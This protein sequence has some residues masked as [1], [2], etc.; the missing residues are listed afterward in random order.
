MS[1]QATVALRASRFSVVSDPPSVRPHL[2]PVG[3]SRLQSV[4]AGPQTASL[5]EGIEVTDPE[6]GRFV[7]QI[8]E[9]LRSTEWPADRTTRPGHLTA[10]AFVLSHDGEEF[11][12]LFHRKLQIWVEPGGHADGDGNLAA[13]ALREATEETGIAG[14]SVDPTPLDVDIHEVRPPAEDPHL[15]F[16]VRFMVLAPASAELRG[17]VESESL[18][19]VSWDELDGYEPDPGLTRLS[20]LARSRYRATQSPS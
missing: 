4:G 20:A 18:R 8:R 9:F 14:L 3:D 6:V 17:N 15:H 12:L 2:W 5:L 13:V 10:S 1:S 7:A 16:D 11:V 19:W